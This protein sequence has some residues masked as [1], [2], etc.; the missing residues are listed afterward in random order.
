[1]LKNICD[2]DVAR[3]TDP[4]EVRDHSLTQYPDGWGEEEA[5]T[6]RRVRLIHHQVFLLC[7]LNLSNQSRALHSKLDP[8]SARFGQDISLQG[9]DARGGTCS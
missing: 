8:S 1:M 7:I 9:Q 5:V 2:L 3:F 6:G 4:C